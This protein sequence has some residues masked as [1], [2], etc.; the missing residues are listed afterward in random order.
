MITQPAL[1]KKIAEIRKAKGM[2]QEE[3]VDRC[4]LNVRTLQRIESG[5]VTPRGYTL[6]IIFAELDYPFEEQLEA[7]VK[8]NPIS[9]TRRSTR[10]H[11]KI[12]T[13]Y[14]FDL[15][16]FK[17]HAMRKIAI[18]T[19]SFSVLILMIVVLPSTAQTITQ[20]QLVGLWRQ[21]G[22]MTVDGKLVSVVTG[23]YRIT[24]PDNTFLMFTENSSTLPNAAFWQ[25][26]TIQ[27]LSDSSSVEQILMHREGVDGRYI[28]V[29]FHFLDENTLLSKWLNGTRW[30][31]ERWER[32][33]V[34]KSNLPVASGKIDV[35]E[36]RGLN[37]QPI[38]SIRGKFK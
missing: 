23:R 10:E 13:F 37:L 21:T 27:Y 34:P 26:G 24:N 19:L 38:D 11:L 16:N 32:I 33:Y 6:K 7:E 31:S 9:K 4:Q 14:L 18:L 25:S 30:I 8:S 5:E 35:K 12:N 22:A 3:L 20:K 28:Q 17:T 29:Q 2:T 1:G 36:F 15:F